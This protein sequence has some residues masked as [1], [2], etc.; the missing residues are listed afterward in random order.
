[1]S[2]TEGAYVVPYLTMMTE[3]P[4]QRVHEFL[5]IFDALRRPVRTGS[6]W[7]YLPGNFPPWEAVYQQ[8]S[9]CIKA[10]S[11][12]RLFTTCERCCG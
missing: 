3:D 7:P 4:P 11:F 8:M 9:R 10:F 12:E 2:D 6:P 1:M 5:D